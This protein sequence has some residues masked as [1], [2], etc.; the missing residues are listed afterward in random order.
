MTGNEHEEGLRPKGEC[1][2]W[3]NRMHPE[4]NFYWQ[5][6]F[7]F[8]MVSEHQLQEVG[9][10]IESQDSVHRD[11]TFNQEITAFRKDGK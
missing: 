10:Y 3:I 2:H 9:T 7:W 6:G 4:M 1:S 11:L 5:K 8:E